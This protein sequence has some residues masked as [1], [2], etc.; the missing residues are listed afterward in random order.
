MVLIA[1]PTRSGIV[2][3]IMGGVEAQVK[4][5]GGDFGRAAAGLDDPAWVGRQM[6]R[7]YGVA[8]LFQALLIAL[9]ALLA[10]ASVPGT[11]VQ[12]ADSMG[13]IGLSLFAFA[14]LVGLL[15]RGATALSP[16]AA[17]VGA[18]VAAAI[19]FAMLFVP[20]AGYAL[21]DTADARELALFAA[22]TLLLLVVA[23]VPALAA[24]KAADDEGE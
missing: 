9:V 4:A 5:C 3:E 16:R 7:V 13:A 22:A 18:A 6:V 20:Q 10:I 8:P 12:P 1:Q 14:A 15:F 2:R 17:L 21:I 24:R 11:L 19:R 23:A